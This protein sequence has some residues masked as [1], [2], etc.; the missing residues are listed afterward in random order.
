MANF[1]HAFGASNHSLNPLKTWWL[2]SDFAQ[3]SYQRFVSFWV[4]LDEGKCELGEVKI[5]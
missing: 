1:R 2:F 3:V 4:R 5:G